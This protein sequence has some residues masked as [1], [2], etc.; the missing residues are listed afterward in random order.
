M[1]KDLKLKS[2]AKLNLYLDI[3]GIQDGLHKLRTV[4]QSISLYDEI[5]FIPIKKKDITI[6][7][8]IKQITTNNLIQKTYYL[9]IK[10]YP[11]QITHG[12]DVILKKN[13]PLG[14]GLG[15]GSSNAAAAFATFLNYFKIQ[16]KLYDL[17]NL[18]LQLGSDV[19]FCY[20][21]GTKL[22]EGVGEQLSNIN[23]HIS[24]NNLQ[25]LETNSTKFLI[26]YPEIHVST[27][28]AYSEWDEYKKINNQRNYFND[29]IQNNKLYN[30]FEQVIFN[31]YPEINDL[32]QNLYKSGANKALMSGSGSTIFGTFTDTKLI[33]EAF[34]YFKGIYPNTFIVNSMTKGFEYL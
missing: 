16:L 17:N 32:K 27:K 6:K 18:L 21:G 34:S 11:Q 23:I 33:N 9:L 22:V 24:K 13:I 8:N 4:M 19:V 1:A 29:L 5:T 31:T 30:S 3:L 12:F 14:A 10:N 26:I 7:S 28:D 2:Y 25:D 15:G 20:Y